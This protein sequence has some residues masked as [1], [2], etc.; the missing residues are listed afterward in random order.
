MF[1]KFEDN[2]VFDDLLQ[3]NNGYLQGDVCILKDEIDQGRFIY[4]GKN[5]EIVF[6]L[7]FKG[8]LKK[9]IVILMWVKLNDIEGVIFFIMV[10]DVINFVCYDLLLC[11]GRGEWVYRGDFGREFFCVQFSLLDIIVGKWYNI[12]GSFDFM[13]IIVLFWVDGK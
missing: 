13:I 1:E 2:L 4:F 3:K 10:I 5:G 12:V 11:N 6:K 8:K 7:G 9:F